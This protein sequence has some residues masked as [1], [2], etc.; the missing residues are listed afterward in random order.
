MDEPLAT[1]GADEDP[2]VTGEYVRPVSPG[3]LTLVGVV[4][5]HP[6]STYRVRRIIDELDPD[7]LAVELP[8]LALPMFEEYAH[9]DRSPPDFGGEMSAAIQAAEA[10][11]VVGIDGPT[12]EFSA[13]LIRR[14]IRKRPASSTVRKVLANLTSA[15]KHAIVCRLAAIVATRTSLRMQVDAPVSHD[16][17]WKD[18]PG[19]QADDEHK[20]IR[21]SR[22][23]MNVFEAS[24]ASH[25]SRFRDETREEHMADRLSELRQE[26][27]VAV[28]GIDH[29]DSLVERLD[30]AKA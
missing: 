15:T 8:P 5:D 7:V 22:A 16:V 20:Q 24:S 2:R 18:A 6:A 27:T 23:F 25:A 30:E 9:D 11:T 4:H 14:L 12:G 28:V 19:E 13:G 17:G 3:G 1:I 29:L 10:D 21:Q 26:R